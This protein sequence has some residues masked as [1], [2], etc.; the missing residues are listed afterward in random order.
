M[1]LLR[2]LFEPVSVAEERDFQRE[3]VSRKLERYLQTNPMDRFERDA[4]Y[5]LKV[6]RIRNGLEK[7][8]GR[9]IEG[10]V[11]DVGG[12]T[13][14][15]ATILQQQ[16][17]RYVVGDINEVALDISRQR[18]RE[19]QL[20]SPAFVAL[21]AHKLPFASDSF[22]AVTVIEALHHFPD[23]ERALAE[24]HR[25]LKPG[26]FFYST[27][28]YALN[29]IRR[30]SEVRDRLRG[31]VEKS[32]Y[33]GQAR[34]LLRAAGFEQVEVC[35][36]AV[37]K[38]SWKMKELP[39]YRRPMAR[40]HEYLQTHLP[41][42]FGSLE[43]RARKG[44]VLEDTPATPDAWKRLLRSPVNGSALQFDPA[45]KRWVAEAGGHTFPDLNGVPV[46][47]P[48][49]ASQTDTHKQAATD[50]RGR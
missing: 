12:N 37:G 42:L 27:E 8:P 3:N 48:A 38:S 44:G 30:L 22:S 26:G 21:D 36:M 6:E 41:G 14:G 4:A 35:I 50:R 17:L 43:L 28:P 13:A 1:A 10:L 46:L 31:S 40:L 7:Q 24:I 19:F 9:L 23:Y 2:H 39:L 34:R 16:G 18:V 15:E 47:V 11:L 5:R 32:F 33:L 29:P 45:S 49:D 25:V 20:Q